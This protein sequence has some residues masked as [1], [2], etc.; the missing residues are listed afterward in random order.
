LN[1]DNKPRTKSEA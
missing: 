1:R